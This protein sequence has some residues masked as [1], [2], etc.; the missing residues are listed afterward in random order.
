MQ[1]I[2]NS[3]DNFFWSSILTLRL[4]GIAIEDAGSL[5]ALLPKG[6][7]VADIPERLALYEK[8]RDGRAH[9]I[10]EF[11]RLAGAD[12]DDERRGDFN[13]ELRGPP[14]GIMSS[15]SD[16]FCSYGIRAVQLWA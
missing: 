12:L 2:S 5:S 7:A 14:S 3:E 15:S 9:K 8:I 11:T 4:G 6:T 16:I 13:S 1:R 10:Q